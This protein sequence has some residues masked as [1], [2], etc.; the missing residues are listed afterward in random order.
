MSIHK[1]E[2]IVIHNVNYD[3]IYF[4]TMDMDPKITD[5]NNYYYIHRI[6]N[7]GDYMSI[8]KSENI[9]IHNVN[10]DEI[11]CKTIDIACV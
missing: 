5:N 1:S 11:Y 6:G 2:N 7:N 3:E 4:K 8:D 9:E 10:Y